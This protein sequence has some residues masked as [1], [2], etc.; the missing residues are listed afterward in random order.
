MLTHTV[1]DSGNVQLNVSYEI[2]VPFDQEVSDVV[3][4]F[5]VEYLIDQGFGLVSQD[6]EFVSA[7]IFLVS[8]SDSLLVLL[9]HLGIRFLVS[10]ATTPT[11][12]I[13]RRGKL[14]LRGRRRS[15]K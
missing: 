9:L 14:C 8:V 5:A 6:R 1:L 3:I 7:D 2:L 11:I 12:T 10:T 13:K 4:I 15:L